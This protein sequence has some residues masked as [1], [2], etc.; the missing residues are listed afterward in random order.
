MSVRDFV[1]AADVKGNFCTR[2]DGV[3]SS[4]LCAFI[5]NIEL[6]ESGREKGIEQ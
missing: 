2:K 5:F 6:H 1:D 3:D 4:V